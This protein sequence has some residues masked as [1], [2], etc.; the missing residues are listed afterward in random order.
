[1]NKI[2]RSM[3]A[4]ST[5]LAVG[6]G[7]VVAT[8]EP[9]YEE[10]ATRDSNLDVVYALQLLGKAAENKGWGAMPD[11]KEAREMAAGSIQDLNMTGEQA[12]NASQAVW[13]LVWIALS[14]LG[15][16]GIYTVA[17]NAGLIK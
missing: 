11:T 6:L 5:A 1:M 8:A 3:V 16:T 13:S 17:Q 15:V 7:G 9:A 14:L 2:T 4:G 12:W 10:Y